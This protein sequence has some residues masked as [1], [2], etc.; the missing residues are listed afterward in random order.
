MNWD[1][2]RDQIWDFIGVIIACLTLVVTLIITYVQKHKKGLTYEF[3]SKAALLTTQEKIKGNLKIFFEGVE[4]DDVRLLEIKVLNSGNIAIPSN[5]YERPLK[6][7]FPKD[8]KI[9]TTEVINCIPDNLIVEFE[10]SDNSITFN[11]VLLN[12]KDSFN[13]KSIVSRFGDG[14][15][16]VDARI[17]DVKEVRK[18]KESGNFTLLYIVG[19]VITLSGLYQLSSTARRVPEVHTPWT[20]ENTIGLTIAFIGI[21]IMI[22]SMLKNNRTRR[23]LF[24]MIAN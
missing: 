21:I 17:K 3:I 20:L 14:E 12:G 24:Q 9:L 19:L 5:D 1:V 7:T 6:F 22:V 13:F 16:N 18:G 8:S 15:I 2:L 4:V 10:L 23:M 11:P